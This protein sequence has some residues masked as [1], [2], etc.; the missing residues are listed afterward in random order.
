MG[1]FQFILLNNAALYVI[2]VNSTQHIP[3]IFI[4][5]IAAFIQ[6]TGKVYV[7]FKLRIP[8]MRKRIIK[9]MWGN[10]K[11][12]FFRK[13]REWVLR[14]NL[15]HGKRM[16]PLWERLPWKALTK[17][18]VEKVNTI[19]PWQNG[20]RFANDISKCICWLI[21]FYFDAKF[22]ELCS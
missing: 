22:T 19:R 18:P 10:K 9:M 3:L 11:W 20:H 16:C 15:S 8:H 12:Q 21:F 4:I 13:Y 5:L 14:D 1:Y 17:S 7:A 2:V 6:V